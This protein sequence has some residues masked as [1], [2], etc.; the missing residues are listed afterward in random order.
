VGI[1]SRLLKDRETTVMGIDSSTNSLAF[2]IITDGHLVKY[3][4][5]FFDGNS[6]YDRLADSQD[7]LL[8]LKDQFDVD[9]IAVEKAILATSGVGTA[10]KMGMALGVVIA[11]VLKDHTT[12]V[13]VP[14][15]S[16]QSYIGN[17]NYDKTKKAAV[18][19]KYSDKSESWIKNKIRE[20]RKQ[21]TIDFFNDKYGID[22]DDNDVGDAIG[23][24]Y[25]ASEHLTR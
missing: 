5:I 17:K 6:A 21:F 3:G 10:I 23:I 9:Y 12:V 1:V 15:I 19:N 16:W 18:R 8:V 4:K 20:D 25:Y 2:A 13:E 22:N 24:A 14:P 7:K 11:C